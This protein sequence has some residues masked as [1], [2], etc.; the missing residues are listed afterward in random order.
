MIKVAVMSTRGGHQ[1]HPQGAC[2]LKG[3]LP[4]PA[5]DQCQPP[6][7]AFQPVLVDH[8]LQCTPLSFSTAMQSHLALSQSTVACTS[9][10]AD[11]TTTQ[12]RISLILHVQQE[13]G[14]M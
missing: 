11:R 4:L 7:L 13:K 5:Q 2:L 10:E 9:V 8:N 1:M 14:S 3:L 6:C 12:H